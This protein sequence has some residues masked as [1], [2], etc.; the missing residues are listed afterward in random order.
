MRA[1][2]I[3]SEGSPLP[4]AQRTVALA[5]IVVLLGGA[6][7]LG[8]QSWRY[9]ALLLIGALLGMSLYHAAFGFTSAYRNA[10]LHRDVTAWWRSWSGSASP[11]L[12][13]APVLARSEASGIA[14]RSVMPAGG[15]EAV[16]PARYTNA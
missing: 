10:L 4:A 5:T 9:G 11:M 2:T 16:P 14:N 7:M 1:S 13:F 8:Q 6:L 3:I 15:V 12:L